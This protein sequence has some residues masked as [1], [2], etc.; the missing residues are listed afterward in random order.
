MRSLFSLFAVCKPLGVAT[1]E[2]GYYHYLAHEDS[3]RDDKFY[4]VERVVAKRVVE[5]SLRCDKT[6]NIM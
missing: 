6:N 1:S 5:V 4:E 2:P 3:S